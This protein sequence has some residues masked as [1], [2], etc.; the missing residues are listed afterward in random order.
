MHD[1]GVG[2]AHEPFGANNM[3][4]PDFFAGFMYEITKV[5]NLQEIQTCYSDSGLV[6][7][8]VIAGVHDIESGGWENDLEAIHNLGLAVHEIP[9]A[10][11]ACE[12]MGDDIAAIESWATI[13]TNKTELIATATKSW[14]FHKKAIKEDLALVEADYA[15][16]AYFHMGEATA[17]LL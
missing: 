13:F 4:I 8:N 3:D 7:G 6:L 10:L 2:A 9:T 17:D 14:L 15:D 11:S 1:N 12:H 16:H 5:D